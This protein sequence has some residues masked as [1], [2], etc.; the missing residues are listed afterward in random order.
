M[1]AV[2]FL[3]LHGDKTFT[4]LCL[5]IVRLRCALSHGLS[6]AWGRAIILTATLWLLQYLCLNWNGTDPVDVIMTELTFGSIWWNVA[7]PK[8]KSILNIFLDPSTGSKSFKNLP[9]SISAVSIGLEKIETFTSLEHIPDI[10]RLCPTPYS[11]N[12][13]HKDGLT[14]SN[15]LEIWLAQHRNHFGLLSS[16][17]MIHVSISS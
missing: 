4:R 3:V 9:N 14:R 15:E 17:H 12:Q 16:E 10:P 6:Q 5:K 1:N 7:P 11:H 8:P 13:L 2:I